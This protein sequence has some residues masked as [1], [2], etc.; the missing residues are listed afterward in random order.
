M[1]NKE[2]VVKRAYRKS[3]KKWSRR[4]VTL[5]SKIKAHIYKVE[6]Q[7]E[8][9]TGKELSNLLN[10]RDGLR[11]ALGIVVENQTT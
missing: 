10:F 8:G 7:L 5:D 9:S 3:H 1:A 2:V 11:L 4:P 6:S